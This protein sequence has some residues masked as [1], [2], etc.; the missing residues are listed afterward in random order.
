MLLMEIQPVWKIVC[1]FL[2]MP[3]RQLPFDPAILLLVNLPMENENI[4]TKL[5]HECYNIII[6]K[7]PKMETIKFPS[8]G[9]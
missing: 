3:T 7:T 8:S 6:N 1:H 9:E 5:V 4:Y 2:K